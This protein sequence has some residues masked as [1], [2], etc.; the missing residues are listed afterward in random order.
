MDR[1]AVGDLVQTPLGKGVVR[2]MRT[3]GRVLVVIVGRNVLVD[4]TDVRLVPAASKPARRRRSP[5]LD[6]QASIDVG[7]PA[8]DRP[9]EVDLHGFVVDDALA[10]AVSAINDALLDG[11]SHLRLI[12]GRSGGRIRA[13]LH[14]QLRGIPSVRSFRLDPSNEGVTIVTF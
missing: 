3:S 9:R 1:F 7:A 4:S 11:A 6:P 5:Q 10:R 8:R 13:A 12:H 14:R 2:E